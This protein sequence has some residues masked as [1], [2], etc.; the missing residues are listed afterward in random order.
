MENTTAAPTF[1]PMEPVLN[2]NKQTQFL[3]QAFE[4]P[5]QRFGEIVQLV[6]SIMK[7]EQPQL[8]Q[9]TEP[10]EA[11]FKLNLELPVV[12]EFL[13]SHSQNIRELVL[14]TFF[15]GNALGQIQAHMKHTAEMMEAFENMPKGEA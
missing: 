12:L 11:G 10:S 14:A 2:L 1:I 8:G 3:P 6:D 5:Q 7:G 4:I 9:P 15:F 13:E